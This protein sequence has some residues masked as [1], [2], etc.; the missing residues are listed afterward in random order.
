[1]TDDEDV[2]NLTLIESPPSNKSSSSKTKS[3]RKN[4][5]LKKPKGPTAQERHGLVGLI[6]LGG[7]CYLNVLLQIW[8]HSPLLR[9][10][11]LNER[12]EGNEPLRYLTVL[13]NLLGMV[14]CVVIILL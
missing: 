2:I 8:F 13:I 11:I 6:N 1:M 7:T 12:R 5:V 10:A 9:A 4:K 14:F 3:P